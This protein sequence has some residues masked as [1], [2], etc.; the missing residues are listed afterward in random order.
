[1]P[2]MPLTPL[3]MAMTVPPYV[4][5]LTDEERAHLMPLNAVYLVQ[6]A[7]M[8][9]SERYYLGTQIIDN[10]RIA[11]PPE[12]EFLRTVVGWPALAVDPYVERLIVDSFHTRNSIQ[13]DQLLSDLW[14]LNNLDAQLPMAINDALTMGRGF[15]LIGVDEDGFAKITAES[16][17]NMAVRWNGS[18]TSPVSAWQAYWQ[19]GRFHGVLMLP[20]RTVVLTT[21]DGG[22]W[23]VLDRDVHNMGFVPLVRMP[24]APR[25]N[26]R[27]GR[28]A[29]TYAIRAVVDSTCRDLLSLEVAREFYSIPRMIL[30]G[31]T[32]ADFINADGS[33][34][35]QWETLITRF[36][37]F[38][39]DDDGETPEVHQMTAYDP[40]VFTKLIDMRASMM[41]AL[42]AAPPQ[43]LGLYTEGN[44]T[45]ADAVD[46]M[47]TRRDRRVK[48]YGRQ[49]GVAIE[50]MLQ[51]AFRVMNGGQLAPQYERIR[52]DWMPPTDINWM[53][54]SQGAAQQVQS[55]I[56]PPTAEPL[57][58]RLGYDAKE[59]QQI[60]GARQLMQDQ[61]MAQQ[62]IEAV[63]S[64]AN[65]RTGGNGSVDSADEHDNS[66]TGIAGV[67]GGTG[68]SGINSG[69]GVSPVGISGARL[70]GSGGSI[71]S[72]VG[73]PGGGL[74]A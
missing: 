17:L 32:E 23:Q 35:T 19:D 36:N 49:F 47:E 45:S 26:A 58:K 18:G 27:D 69:A 20:D 40:S 4:A 28:T 52:T 9:L 74:G 55:G 34:K 68:I 72:G 53:A 66:D 71:G 50:E 39:R 60:E 42:V 44:P 46:A 12:L 59:R 3:D 7:E 62:I 30:L 57:L 15:W 61:T 56:V 5:G 37:A 41:A 16:P 48:Q 33:K 38:R 22:D 67:N 11:V 6:Q 29:I 24:N 21:D 8:R 1:M 13:P 31:A 70:S 2:L 54:A 64:A 43:D 73:N 25:S 51:T 63:R 14:E 10:L 65:D